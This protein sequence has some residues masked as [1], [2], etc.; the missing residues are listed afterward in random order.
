MH[1]FYII[2]RLFEEGVEIELVFGALYKGEIVEILENGVMV[3][4]KKGMR[5]IFMRNRYLK[6][7]VIQ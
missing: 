2:F 5:P 4:L 6:D 7:F 1:T 3:R